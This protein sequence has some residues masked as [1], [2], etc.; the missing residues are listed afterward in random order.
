MEQLSDTWQIRIFRPGE[1]PLQSLAL[2]FVDANLSA[3][4]RAKQL[5]DAEDLIATRCNGVATVGA[6]FTK[7][8]NVGCGSV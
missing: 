4:E 2:V 6:V 3:V 1:H 8:G 5:G 7:S